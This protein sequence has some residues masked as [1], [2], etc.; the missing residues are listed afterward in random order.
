[1]KSLILSRQDAGIT[2]IELLY[3]VVVVSILSMLMLQTFKMWKERAGEAVSNQ[4]LYDAR[5]AFSAGTVVDDSASGLSYPQETPGE[6]I[7]A[8]ARK[9]LPGFMLPKNTKIAIEY[10][11]NCGGSG[12]LSFIETKH[13]LAKKHMTWTRFC[14]GLEL[15]IELP[16][17]QSTCS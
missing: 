2:L 6:L 3:T 16:G 15:L 17:S 5:V 1:M 4:A 11:P 9:L 13:C 8:E 10:A 12:E 14:D 7:D